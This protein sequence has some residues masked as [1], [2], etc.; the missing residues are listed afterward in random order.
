MLA[1]R[2]VILTSALCFLTALHLWS[3]DPTPATKPT[4]DSLA[5]IASSLK[6]QTGTV[7]LRD[8]L[9]KINLTDNF[10]FLDHENAQK[11]L[12]DIWGNP[13]D[14]DVLG[15]I[16]P[17]DVGPLDKGSWGVIVEYEENGYVKDDDAEKIDY[18][19][20]LK[21]MQQETR[22]AN[23]ERQK[24]GY[25]AFDLVGWAAPPHYDKATHKLYWAKDVK[26]GDDPEDTLNYNIRVLGRRGVLVLNAVASMNEFASIEKKMP[27]VISMVDF[28]AGNQY[29]DFDPKI[30][31]IAEYGLATLVAGGALGAAA[32]LGLLAAMWKFLLAGALALKKVIILAVVAIV[33][34][35]KKI[36]GKFSGKSSTPDHLLPP[37]NKPPGPPVS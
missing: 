15:M 18:T 36:M 25:P 17:A 37:E 6:W 2:F 32:K 5:A 16:F 35:F 27:D 22:D 26:F 9:A 31:K 28:Q 13:A 11:V 1:K 12:H 30:D 24:E 34:G 20:L 29:T 3:D 10:R 4:A 23:T 21:K 19:D 7:T 33:A 14:P 8:G